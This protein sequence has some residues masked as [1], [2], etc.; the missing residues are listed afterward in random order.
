MWR[1]NQSKHKKQSNLVFLS[2]LYWRMPITSLPLPES[3][4][5]HCPYTG[6]YSFLSHC[7]ERLLIPRPVEFVECALVLFSTLSIVTH[8]AYIPF[9]VR[10][11]LDNVDWIEWN[12]NDDEEA[13][14]KI[15]VL[16]S[17]LDSDAP[18]D[19][20]LLS[21]RLQLPLSARWLGEL[22]WARPE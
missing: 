11:D 19:P 15:M 1:V 6:C 21:V 17:T 20:P 13:S 7:W 5:F 4:P 22:P 18:P 14:A 2:L 8:N 3:H 10:L 9:Q 12:G 16:L